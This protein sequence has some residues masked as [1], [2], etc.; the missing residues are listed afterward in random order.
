MNRVFNKVDKII[1]VSGVGTTDCVVK[2]EDVVVSVVW[3]AF[4][5][6]VLILDNVAIEI[7]RLAVVCGVV[8]V[9]IVVLVTVETTVVDLV[10]NEV[11]K[12]VVISFTVVVD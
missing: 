9:E 11:D 2:V 12:K 7:T 1:V 4:V 3:I 5:V 8:D 6:W 10:F